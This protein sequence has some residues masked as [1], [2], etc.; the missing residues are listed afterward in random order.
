MLLA[1]SCMLAG[2]AITDAD[3]DPS[4]NS[5]SA[6]VNV[7]AVDDDSGGGTM[8]YLFLLLTCLKC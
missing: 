6:T 3:A 1:L 2:P 4:N 5:A 8:G 7:G